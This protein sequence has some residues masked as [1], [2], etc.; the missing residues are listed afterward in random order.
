MRILLTCIC[1]CF[2]SFS[3]KAQ[4]YETPASVAIILDGDSGTVLFE[5]N[6]RE[7][8]APASMTKIMTLYMVF[9][10]L[11]S[12]SLSL[13]D[14]FTVSEDAWNR[15]GFRSGSSTMCLR[16]NERVRVED[17]IRGVVVLSGNDAAITIAENI[18]GSE[19]LFAKA[20]TARAHEL[21]LTSAN[22]VNSTGWPAENHVISAFDLAQIAKLTI[23]KFPEFYKYYA[24]REYD[25]CTAAPSNRYNRNPLLSL[26]DGADGLKT[27]YTSEAGYS[28]IAA[29][30]RD[31]ERRIVVVSGLGTQRERSRQ[32]ERVMRAAF[33]EFTVKTLF[34]APKDV[35]RINVY[36]GQQKT[37][38]V[39]PAQPLTIGLF[40]QTMSQVR[41]QII[42]EGAV[43]APVSVGQKMAILRI[44]APGQV[45]IEV[46]LL[47]TEAVPRK[48]FLS[49]AVTGL[50]LMIQGPPE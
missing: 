44:S 13:D 46:D 18:S 5:K 16:P 24:E 49:R 48:G 38:A 19:A 4:G 42:Y 21:G 2:F 31:G 29:A 22:F 41:A 28:L 10:R 14:E 9:E 17:L 15:G 33:G 26:F 11:A 35:G 20:M 8:I 37:V 32:A 50:V 36:L 47:A 43:S 12:G 39:R 6:A 25:W 23:Q 40:K 34:E 30:E 7:P 3:A 45:D 27:G 1:L